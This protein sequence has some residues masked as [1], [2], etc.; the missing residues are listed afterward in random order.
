METSIIEFYYDRYDLDNDVDNI[1]IKLTTVNIDSVF[2]MLIDDVKEN[3]N[4]TAAN[5]PQFSNLEIIP[6][7][8]K[9]VNNAGDNLIDYEYVGNEIKKSRTYTAKVKYGENHLK[10][11]HQMGL[12]SKN[13]F[14]VTNLGKI[15]MLLKKEEQDEINRK[16]YMRIPIVQK[17]LIES[18]LNVIDAMKILE[19]YLAKKTAIRRRSNVR[20]LIHE[21]SKSAGDQLKEQIQN[22]IYWKINK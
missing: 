16:L 21:I 1:F 2:R 20:K 15:Y 11:A 9:I 3:S 7:V 13:P 17:L 22:N 19:E 8:L 18:E 10:L 4:V 14:K 6:L 12:L 5:I